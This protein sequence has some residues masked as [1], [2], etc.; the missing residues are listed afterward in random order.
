VSD[1]GKALFCEAFWLD[2][3]G[4]KL[5]HFTSPIIAI[6]YSALDA[7]FVIASK[8]GEFAFVPFLQPA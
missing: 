1:H 6:V 2:F 4:V 7:G 5:G 8:S 3:R